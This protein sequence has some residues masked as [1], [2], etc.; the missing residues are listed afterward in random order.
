M[1][2]GWTPPP[3]VNAA[4]GVGMLI[5]GVAFFFFTPGAAASTQKLVLLGLYVLI[6]AFYLVRAYR[7]YRDRQQL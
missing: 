7:Q 1:R 4:F 6:A 2:R 3:W 5:F